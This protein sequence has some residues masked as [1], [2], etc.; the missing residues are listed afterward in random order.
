MY[1]QPSVSPKSCSQ[2]LTSR[3]PVP[4]EAGFGITIVPL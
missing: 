3:K 2:L 4:D 1:F